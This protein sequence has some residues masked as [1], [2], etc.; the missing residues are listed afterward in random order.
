MFSFNFYD[1][2][3]QE[4]TPGTVEEEDDV[5]IIPLE[6]IVSLVPNSLAY[7]FVAGL[8]R[9]ELWHVKMQLMQSDENQHL[10]GDSDVIKGTYE[11]GLKTWEC[12]IDL[13]QYLSQ[14]TFPEEL[15]ILE[16]RT[17]LDPCL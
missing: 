14:Q 3:I 11:G 16:V 10:L 5:K 17:I 7:S 9:R 6:D 2:P 8:P 1:D 13:A 4:E 12:S 15:S